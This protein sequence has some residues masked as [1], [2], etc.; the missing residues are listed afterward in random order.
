MDQEFSPNIGDSLYRRFARTRDVYFRQL[1]AFLTF[2]K[3]SPNGLTLLGVLV[4]LGFAATIHESKALAVSCLVAAVFLD[5]LDG[6]LARY[7]QVSSDR[8]KFFDVM[9]D[10][11]GSFLFAVGLVADHLVDPLIVLSY[12]YFML[13]SKVFKIYLNSF[14]YNS[15]WLFRPVAGFVTSFLNY[16]AYLLFI[17]HVLKPFDMNNPMLVMTVILVIYAIWH[18]IRIIRIKPL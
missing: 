17:I 6:V 8:G 3:F 16:V 10:N 18:F 15:D 2:C 13:L 9:N 5:S 14:E 12:V 7:Q 1:A 11:L 4:M